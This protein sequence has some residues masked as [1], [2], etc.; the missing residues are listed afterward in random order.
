[1]ILFLKQT[2]TPK[3]IE[4]IDTAET[5][6]IVVGKGSVSLTTVKMMVSEAPI[7]PTVSFA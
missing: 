4:V 1:M 3:P 7:F 5:T 6:T 2:N